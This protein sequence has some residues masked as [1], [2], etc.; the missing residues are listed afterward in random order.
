MNLIFALGARMTDAQ[1]AI[2]V[3]THHH[4]NRIY[5][6]NASRYSSL[7]VKV[8]LLDGEGKFLH[9]NALAAVAVVLLSTDTSAA[10]SS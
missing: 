4:G 3:I 5:G 7:V 8:Q 9:Q 6:F 1:E 10:S 2:Q